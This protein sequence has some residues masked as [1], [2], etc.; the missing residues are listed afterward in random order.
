MPEK[1]PPEVPPA[2]II[3]E[4]RRRNRRRE[5]SRPR[6]YDRPLEYEPD[7]PKQDKAPPRV[8]EIRLEDNKTKDL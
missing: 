6:V 2:H 7:E 4:M 5:D 1:I 8:V 3:D